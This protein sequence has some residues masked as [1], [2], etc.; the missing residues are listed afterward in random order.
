MRL[1][2]FFVTFTLSLVFVFWFL[3]DFSLH[4]VAAPAPADQTACGIVLSKVFLFL[5]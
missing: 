3:R 4:N 5:E 1:G 2:H